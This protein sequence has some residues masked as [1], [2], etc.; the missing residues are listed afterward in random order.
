MATSPLT[1]AIPGI[2]R[3]PAA[4]APGIVHLGL[5]N[6]HRAHQAVYTDAAITANGGDWG[7][8]GVAS[9]S[10]TI[11]DAMRAQDMLYTVVEISPA[12][13]GFTVPRVHTDAFTAAADPDRV[14]KAIGDAG[15]RIVSLTVTENGYNYTPATGSLNLQDPA[16]R[17]DVAHPGSPQTPIGQIV[18]G[19]QH[20]SRSHG[21][22]VAILS[23]DNLAD[24]GHH[25]QRLVREFASLLPAAEAAEALAFIDACTSFPS[26]MVDRIVPATTDHYRRM[27][28]SHRGYDDR[29][30]V[31]A[32][33]FSM[34]IIEDNFISGRPTWEDGGAVFSDEV[35]GYEQ[36]KVRLLNGTH[37]LIAYLGALAG[38]VTIPESVSHPSI[39]LAARSVLR[40]EYLPSVSVPRDVDVDAYEEELFT[41]WRNTALGHRTSQVGSDGSVK[42]RQRIPL[43]AL[44]MLDDGGMPQLLAL[45]T[46]A[47]LA[48]IAPLP[49]FDPG[50]QAHAM[51]D[52]ARA[53]LAGLA[54][55]SRSGHD[56]ARKVIGDH[57]LLGEELAEREAFILRT[58]EFIDIIHTAG[59][60]AAI[61]EAGTP[62]SL[63]SA[64][65]LQPTRSTP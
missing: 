18:R 25:T 52:P 53:M 48:C 12:G 58:G 6:F 56:L 26:S 16:I 46:A 43:P 61:T 20:R 34:W 31:A 37:S 60:L 8:I 50:P 10:T 45:T 5:G 64:P 44:Q 13:S 63:A 51:E 38:A 11:P 54:A 2:L 57:H 35:A 21:E 4:P 39:E 27:V 22:P 49:G 40:H 36:L 47:Y 65:A 24:N 33:P 7:I 15:T 29:I 9:R 17:H 32:E 1:A 30:P 62:A 55:G 42:L 41:R 14:T 23:C 3:R 28:A 59:P 19:L